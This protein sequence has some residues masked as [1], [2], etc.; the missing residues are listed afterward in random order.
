MSSQ[1]NYPITVHVENI[2]EI[3]VMI[4]FSDCYVAFQTSVCQMTK[5]ITVQ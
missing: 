5:C 2:L 4:F 3:H 1:V